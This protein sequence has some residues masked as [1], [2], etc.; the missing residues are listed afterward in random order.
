VKKALFGQT[1]GELNSSEMQNAGAE[2]AIYSDPS[3]PSPLDDP[4][5]DQNNPALNAS[6]KENKTQ[7]EF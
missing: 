1:H 2:N 4:G 7:V 6:S 3:N 5:P